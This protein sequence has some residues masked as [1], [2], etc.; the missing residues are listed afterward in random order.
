MNATS[1][2]P[3]C[4]EIQHDELIYVPGMPVIECQFV[5]SPAAAAV[6][7]RGDLDIVVCCACG[8]IFNRAFDPE[9]IAYAPGY[10]N[11]LGFSA[12]HRA[13]IETTIRSLVERYC[14][15]AKTI[16]EIG[17][18]NAD[19]LRRLCA[20]GGNRGIG[21]DPSQTTRPPVSEGSGTVEI[22]GLGFDK[23]EPEPAD[24]I[25]AQHVLEHLPRPVDALRH[26]YRHV[27]PGGLGYFEVPNAASIFHDLSIWDLTYEHVSYFTKASLSSALTNAGFSIARLESTFGRQYLAAEVIAGPGEGDPTQAEAFDHFPQLFVEITESWRKALTRWTVTGERVILWGAG[28]KAVSFLN[29]L[30]VREGEG[31][32]YVVDINPRKLGSYIPGTGQQI[33]APDFLREYRPDKVVIMNREYRAEIETQLQKLKIEAAILDGVPIV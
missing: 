18:G 29:M 15:R 17:C 16:I 25:C 1:F 30:G 31:I 28:A 14:L 33:I 21:Y 12:R 10:E 26:A 20:E 32:D 27:V 11:A 23:A 5:A 7:P 19:F 2:C 13:Y 24:A 4:N 9:R 3:V 8:H 22:V 6:I